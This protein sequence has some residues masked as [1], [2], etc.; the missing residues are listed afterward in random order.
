MLT[1]SRLFLLAAVFLLMVSTTTTHA[2]NARPLC[3][4]NVT[5]IPM[6]FERVLE[7]QT[8]I[9]QRGKVVARGES[10]DIP[11]GAEVIDGRGRYLVPGFA[12]MHAHLP[13]PAG[14]A[15]RM[16]DYLYLQLANGVT[17]LRVTRDGKAAAEVQRR[18]EAGE[19]IGPIL[20]VAAPSIFPNEFIE[21]DEMGITLAQYKREGYDFLKYLAKSEAYFD[22]LAPECEKVGLRI[23]GHAPEGGLAQALRHNMASVEHIS[24]FVDLHESDPEGLQSAIQ[25]M[26]ER[27]MF[28]CPDVFWYEVVWLQHRLNKL[29]ELPG[30]SYVDP[31]VRA[32]WA[33]EF[34]AYESE[35][36]EKY[37]DGYENRISMRRDQ[38]ASFDQILRELQAASVPL[39]LSPAEGWF[40]VPGFAFHEEMRIWREAGLTNWE[41]LQAA[42]TQAAKF[43]DRP[44]EEGKIE[45]GQAANLVLLNANPL[46]DIENAR[47]VQGVILGGEWYSRTEIE[48]HLKRIQSRF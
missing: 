24:P 43:F 40:T 19:L 20:S 44:G 2:V 5:V 46:S 31:N 14:G 33:E 11:L 7:N 29:Q 17:H 47:K 42:T 45:V 9:V 1:C 48:E 18:I 23:V 4:T 30:L 3:I 35:T 22:L 34:A 12:D 8:V 10:L 26:G 28:V 13:G 41:I 6:D 32:T 37:G 39:L 27:G 15:H 36:R 38:L 21:P 25:E 16:D